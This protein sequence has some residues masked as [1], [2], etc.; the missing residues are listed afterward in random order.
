M[1]VKGERCICLAYCMARTDDVE[2][3]LYLRLWGVP[4][5]ALAHVFGR[6]GMF[7]YRTRLALR[8]ANL[9]GATVK[10]ESAMPG[11]LIADEKITWGDGQEVLS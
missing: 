7:W 8:P 5:A 9:V 3:A 4:F 10:S 2:K 11:D 1:E 6:N